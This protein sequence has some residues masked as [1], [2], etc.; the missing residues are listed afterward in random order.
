MWAPQ[1]ADLALYFLLYSEGANLRHMPECLWFLFW[2]LQHSQ[3]R[4]AA[5]PPAGEQPL[6]ACH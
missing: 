1:L 3:R 4:G 6:P 2:L 5:L